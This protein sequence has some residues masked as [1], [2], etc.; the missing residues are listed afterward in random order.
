MTILFGC[1]SKRAPLEFITEPRIFLRQFEITICGEIPLGSAILILNVNE[2]K[3]F[4]IM[5]ESYGQTCILIIE[6]E[7][8]ERGVALMAN[9][10]SLTERGYGN[11]FIN[12]VDLKRVPNR[13][14]GCMSRYNG[15]RSPYT[16]HSYNIRCPSTMCELE[17][18]AIAP[19]V[20]IN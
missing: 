10:T 20:L 3:S 11:I 13:A 12:K 6:S 8:S 1:I 19:R 7:T 15:H 5:I 17:C 18:G 14:S 4:L 9:S 2:E 16:T